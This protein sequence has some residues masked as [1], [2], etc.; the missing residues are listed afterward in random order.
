MDTRGEVDERVAGAQALAGLRRDPGEIVA[1]DHALLRAPVA[2][3][4]TAHQRDHLMA[5]FD[6]ESGHRLADKSVG[7]TDYD[8]HELVR[9][10]HPFGRPQPSSRRPGEVDQASSER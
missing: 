5:L 2:A 8:S 7:T 10:F 3:T 6:R 4:G 9:G 1:A